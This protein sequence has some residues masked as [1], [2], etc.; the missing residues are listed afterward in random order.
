M[1]SLEHEHDCPP[2]DNERAEQER[3]DELSKEV[4]TWWWNLNIFE[5]YDEIRH[6]PKHQQHALLVLAHNT[7]NGDDSKRQISDLYSHL[8]GMEIHRA[9]QY[10][11]VTFYP[12]EDR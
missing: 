4:S 3:N 10:G 5:I 6:R 9:K 2:C 11:K 8:I 1:S 7:A 12:K